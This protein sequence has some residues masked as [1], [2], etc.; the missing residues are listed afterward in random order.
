M[1]AKRGKQLLLSVY[2]HCFQ[3]SLFYLLMPVTV[4]AFLLKDYLCCRG[5]RDQ[6]EGFY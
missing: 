4:A 6:R 5:R 3:M 2:N 1:K